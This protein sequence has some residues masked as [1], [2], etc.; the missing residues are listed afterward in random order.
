M[1]KLTIRAWLWT[2]HCPPEVMADFEKLFALPEKWRKLSKLTSVTYGD[3]QL[4]KLMNRIA[5]ELESIL[6]KDG[7]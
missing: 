4:E 7:K 6:G 5:D 3:E 1:P 2:Q